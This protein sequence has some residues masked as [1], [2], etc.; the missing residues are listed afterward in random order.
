MLGTIKPGK[1]HG[2]ERD[3]FTVPLCERPKKLWGY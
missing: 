1:A 3:I 2:R